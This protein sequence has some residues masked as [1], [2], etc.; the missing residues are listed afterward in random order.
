MRVNIIRT[1]TDD[2]WL[3]CQNQALGTMR[4]KSQNTPSF[5]LRQKY[6]ASE[7]SPIVT[8]IYE[9]EWLDLPYWISVHFVR[10]WLGVKHFVSSQRND[11][12]DE[13]DRQKA[14]Q[15]A[16]V[17]HRIEANAM[18]MI[19]ISQARKCLE[20]STETRMA[21]EMAVDEISNHS[22]EIIPFLVKPCIYRNGICPEVF[23][24]C[25]YNKTDKFGKEVK[26]YRDIYEK[27]K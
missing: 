22:Q 27:M 23:G 18:S 1:P 25:A 17:N 24:T 3:R 10:H 11:R 12:Q 15:D 14:P 26:T 19:N 16:L 4:K 8:L 2:D 21:W 5:E 20:A 13:Y 9:W 6:L 7:H